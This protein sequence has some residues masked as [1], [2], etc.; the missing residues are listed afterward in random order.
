MIS[1]KCCV[2]FVIFI[3]Q[4]KMLMCD[5]NHKEEREK[6]LTQLKQVSKLNTG[7]KTQNDE[8]AVTDFTSLSNENLR[9]AITS[10]F[11]QLKFSYLFSA[12]YHFSIVDQIFQAADDSLL[13]TDLISF[14]DESVKMVSTFIDVKGIQVS[15]VWLVYNHTITMSKCFQLPLIKRWIQCGIRKSIMHQNNF[16]VTELN[17]YLETNNCY[18]ENNFII[19]SGKLVTYDHSARKLILDNKTLLNQLHKGN[20]EN[21]LK[22]FINPN[23][24]EAFLKTAIEEIYIKFLIRFRTYASCYV[25]EY[26]WNIL[27][28]AM[29]PYLEFPKH[30]GFKGLLM[31]GKLNL[32][33]IDIL[34]FVLL[35][36]TWQ[37]LIQL[38]NIIKNNYNPY[39]HCTTGLKESVNSY[40]RDFQLI[41]QNGIDLLNLNDDD[42]FH[43]L[44]TILKKGL[45]PLEYMEPSN[46]IQYHL[47]TAKGFINET[48]RYIGDSLEFKLYQSY[49]KFIRDYSDRISMFL[50]PKTVE[51]PV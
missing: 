43:E 22:S 45:H 26:N 8:L 46:F 36:T 39:V 16:V 30:H 49:L 51:K 19:N 10:R 27:N 9:Q 31:F 11:D 4:H 42:I 32:M 17:K 18:G 44:N 5:D 23:I 13:V 34:R 50:N 2:L 35:R 29:K 7:Y 37:F 15:E 38:N 20:L 1:T 25:Y 47:S 41:L 3:F 6:L 21:G 14:L 12:H 40:I 33:I 48:K 28:Q 24:N